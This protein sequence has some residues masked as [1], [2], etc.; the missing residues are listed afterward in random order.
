MSILTYTL[1]ELLAKV[2][3]STELIL[4]TF[5]QYHLSVL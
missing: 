4:I 5:Q 2:D 3:Y 1:K